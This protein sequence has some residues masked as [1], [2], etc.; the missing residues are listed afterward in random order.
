MFTSPRFPNPPPE[1][2]EHEEATFEGVG[3][4]LTQWEEIEQVFGNLYSGFIGKLELIDAIRDYGAPPKLIFNSRLNGLR[5]AAWAY[6][7]S[8]PNQAHEGD[9]DRIA[10]QAS[11]FSTNRNDI[12]HGIVRPLGYLLPGHKDVSWRFYLLP[13]GYRKKYFDEF[14]LPAYAYDSA[15]MIKL[16]S[17]LYNFADDVLRFR[18]RL[19]DYSNIYLKNE[20]QP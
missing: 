20:L 18:F 11:D 16:E 9:F 5:A 3:R 14:Q 1:G 4:V 8:K 6:F 12:A 2:D 15:S 13:P 10:A 17:E 19:W 7:C